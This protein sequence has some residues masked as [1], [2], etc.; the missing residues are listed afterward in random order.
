MGHDFHAISPSV[1]ARVEVCL[2]LGDDTPRMKLTS[3]SVDLATRESRI[4]RDE[5]IAR[6]RVIDLNYVATRLSGVGWFLLKAL[7]AQFLTSR[8]VRWR[9]LACL[10]PSDIISTRTMARLYPRVRRAVL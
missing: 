2:V 6:R 4:C 10:A 5:V 1:G 3:F 8:N 7:V 9:A